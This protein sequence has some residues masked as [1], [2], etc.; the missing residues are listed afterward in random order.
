MTYQTFLKKQRELSEAKW[1][2]Y[3]EEN[4]EKADKIQEELDSLVDPR[5]DGPADDLIFGET[6]KETNRDWYYNLITEGHGKDW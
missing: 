5:E 4:Y 1:A 2:A 3:D 6:P